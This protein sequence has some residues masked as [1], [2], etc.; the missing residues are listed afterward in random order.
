MEYNK[1]YF[2]C[3]IIFSS[4]SED[5]QYYLISLPE[6][7]DKTKPYIETNIIVDSLNIYQYLLK[8]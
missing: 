3:H 7:V 8:K 6:M 1:Q 2:S 5:F 4:S